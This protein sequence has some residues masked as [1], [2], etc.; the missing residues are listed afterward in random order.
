[1][2]AISWSHH[3]N[4]PRVQNLSNIFIFVSPSGQEG[5]QC[6]CSTLGL[7]HDVVGQRC[8]MF[9]H[10]TFPCVAMFETCDKKEIF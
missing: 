9:R 1:M 4:H 6:P 5:Q 10:A 7:A 2:S 8:R 3:L